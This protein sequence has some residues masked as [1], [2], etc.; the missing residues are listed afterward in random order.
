MPEWLHVIVRSL[1]YL[2]LL[3]FVTKLLGK[4]QISELSF[5][6]Y[7]SGITIG[8]VAGEVIMGL[9]RHITYGIISIVIFAI[10]TLAADFFGL[11]SKKFRDFVEGKS[12][13][14]IEQGKILEGN[15]KKE[16]YSSDELLALLRQKGIFNIADVE[17]AAIEPRGN[18][19]VLLKKENQ[20]V[21]PKDLH[22]KVDNERESQTVIMDGNIL[23]NS[24]QKA[25]KSRNWLNS[26]LKKLGVTVDNVFLA[27]IDSYGELT[28]DLYDDQLKVPFP[29][30]RPLILAMLKKTQADLELFALGANQTPEEKKLYSQNA[31]QLSEVIAHL[32]PFLT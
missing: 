1:V 26:E 25:K 6:E 20:P 29:Q 27:Q 16:K 21:T 15:L 13:I 17:F 31:K 23:D 9:E 30:Q 32:E 3:F 12:T 7:I 22:L 28:V 4:K 2:V 11:K 24:L 8:S 18:L 19:S 10:L 14:F 5:F